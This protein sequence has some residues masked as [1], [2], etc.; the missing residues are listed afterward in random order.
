MSLNEKE[1]IILS[2]LRQNA[3][4]NLTKISRQTGIPVS[5]LFDKLRKYQQGIIT[6]QTV[7]LDFSKLGF[8]VKV[9]TLLKIAKDQKQ[10]LTTY[11]INSPSVNSISSV[12]GGFDLLIEAIFRNLKELEL[13]SDQLEGFNIKKKEEFFV[14]EDIK[15]ESFLAHPDLIELI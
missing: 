10:E 2:H 5:T 1:L 11:L 15:R 7:L 13:F 14:V 9:K 12:T 4:K 3:R 8:D 6:K